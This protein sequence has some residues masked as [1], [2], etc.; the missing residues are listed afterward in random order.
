MCTHPHLQCL[1]G[2]DLEGL[3]SD[4]VKVRTFE[5]SIISSERRA[6]P[7]TLVYVKSSL[8]TI[9]ACISIGTQQ[10]CALALV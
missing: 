3:T 2:M 8:I 10:V 7:R 1:L 9:V 6:D 4:D 5:M